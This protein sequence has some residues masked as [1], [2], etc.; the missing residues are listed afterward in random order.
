MGYTKDG[1]GWKKGDE[2]VTGVMGALADSTVASLSTDINEMAI[3]KL[4]GHTPSYVD[5]EGNPTYKKDAEGNLIV[6][7]E[8]NP[9]PEIHH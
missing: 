5:D 3:G 6:D 2:P 8:G 1:E 4:L 7:E 9:I